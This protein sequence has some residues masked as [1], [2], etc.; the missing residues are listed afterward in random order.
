M[1][2]TTHKDV[3]DALTELSARAA[4][5]TLADARVEHLRSVIVG[6]IMH[7]RMS[8][9]TAEATERERANDTAAD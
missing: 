7:L 9:L 6:Y 8:S 4:N 2:H 1:N 3:L 5:Y